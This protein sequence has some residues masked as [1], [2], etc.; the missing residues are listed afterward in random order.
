MCS[1]FTKYKCWIFKHNCW[2]FK[3]IDPLLSECHHTDLYSR[4]FFLRHEINWDRKSDITERCIIIR[5][6]HAR[7]HRLLTARGTR[8]LPN[9]HLSV[10][11][12]SKYFINPDVLSGRWVAVESVTTD[13]YNRKL[14]DPPFLPSKWKRIFVHSLSIRY[15]GN[16]NL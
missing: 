8:K 16:T 4:Y 15:R 10:T 7:K 5:E 3:H 14:V 11:W 9:D 2:M 1:K 6:S 13:L 12:W